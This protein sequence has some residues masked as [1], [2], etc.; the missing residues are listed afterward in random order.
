MENHAPIATIVAKPFYIKAKLDS[1]VRVDCCETLPSLT[2]SRLYSRV[3]KG[4]LQVLCDLAL[5]LVGMGKRDRS[6]VRMEYFD[7]GRFI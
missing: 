5:E 3:L 2:K 4:D 6:E 1:C 7:V